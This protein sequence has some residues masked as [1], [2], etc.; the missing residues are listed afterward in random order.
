MFTNKPITGLTRIMIRVVNEKTG[1]FKASL[2]LDLPISSEW[3]GA[4]DATT[5]FWGRL[6]WRV[7][8]WALVPAVLMFA[9]VLCHSLILG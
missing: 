1:F 8:L 2:E 5:Q 7:G 4:R 9:L 3:K 6:I